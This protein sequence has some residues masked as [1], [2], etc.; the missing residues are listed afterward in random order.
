ML[1]TLWLHTTTVRVCALAISSY[2]FSTVFLVVMNDCNELVACFAMSLQDGSSCCE[3]S[4][5]T[6]KPPQQLHK[7]INS[8]CWG[9]HV[10]P[11]VLKRQT[12]PRNNTETP[13][14]H[15]QTNYEKAGE[16]RTSVWRGVF[17]LSCSK[18]KMFIKSLVNEHC[19]IS[20]GL[21][22]KKSR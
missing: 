14:T 20:P 16:V 11:A 21:E 17:L 15:T 9:P 2:G 18:L 4:D 6:V 12:I 19:H 13:H 22:K 3:I 5:S 1:S 10:P 7:H 8:V